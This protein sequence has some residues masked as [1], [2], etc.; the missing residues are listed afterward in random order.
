LRA[1]FDIG[2]SGAKADAMAIWIVQW[3][4]QEIRVLDYIEGVGQ[5]LAYYVNELRRRKYQDAICY[6]PHDGHNSNAITGKTYAQHLSD[7]DFEVEVIPNQGAGAAAMRIEATRRILP[8][9]W[10]NDATTEAGRE[11]LGFYHER[12]DETRNI[13]LGPD[14]DWSSHCADAFG[15]MAIIWEPQATAT[16][17]DLYGEMSYGDSSRS[18]ITGY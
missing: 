17:N 12:K 2:G 16:I 8:Y 18:E 14:H 7:A 15:M 1:F 4:G 6:L 5:V 9:C 13:G 11:A 10:F 3:V